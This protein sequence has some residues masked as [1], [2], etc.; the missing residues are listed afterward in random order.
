MRDMMRDLVMPCVYHGVY[1]ARSLGILQDVFLAIFLKI[2]Q[3][4]TKGKPKQID[5]EIGHLE[6]R[7]E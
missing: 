1:L 3:L 2:L 6:K 5:H 7:L 4:F